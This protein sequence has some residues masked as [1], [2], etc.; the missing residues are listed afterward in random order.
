M[1]NTVSAEMKAAVVRRSSPFSC[2]EPATVSVC[3]ALLTLP[4][5]VVAVDDDANIS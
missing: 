3:A 2:V 4:R 1:L 5:S